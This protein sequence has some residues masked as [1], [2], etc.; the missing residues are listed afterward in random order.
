LSL[1]LLIENAAKHNRAIAAQPLNVQ[2]YMEGDELCVK[3]NLQPVHF[4]QSGTGLGLVNL[5]ERFKILLKKEIS[6]IRT[7]DS[8]L[9]KLPL[10]NNLTAQ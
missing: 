9:V 7:A 8:F 6:I 2:V 3:N 5:D 10:T 1:Q 4:P